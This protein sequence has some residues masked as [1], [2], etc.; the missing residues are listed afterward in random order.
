VAVG[1]FGGVVAAMPDGRV[2]QWYSTSSG[3]QVGEVNLGVALKN[4]VSLW[5][6]GDFVAVGVDEEGAPHMFVGNAI[7]GREHVIAHPGTVG[8]TLYGLTLYG[9][10]SNGY[11]ASQAVGAPN[12]YADVA[13]VDVAATGVAASPKCPRVGGPTIIPCFGWTTSSDMGEVRPEFWD[14]EFIWALGQAFLDPASVPGFGQ[15]SYPSR[16]PGPD[17]GPRRFLGLGDPEF[18]FDPVHNPLVFRSF[19][20]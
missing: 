3:P 6:T 15:P 11:A 13:D 20:T 18:P 8:V 12:T 19:C 2:K 14:A 10:T 7:D 9:V 16:P 5:G 17:N 1:G 4:V